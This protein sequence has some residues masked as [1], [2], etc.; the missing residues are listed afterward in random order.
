MKNKK[1]KKKNKFF[2][3]GKKFQKEFLVALLITIIFLIV[4]TNFISAKVINYDE[5]K[6]YIIDWLKNSFKFT[7]NQ[8]EEESLN[9]IEL[10]ELQLP[11]DSN[12]QKVEFAEDIKTEGVCID[13]LISSLT[14]NGLNSN[15]FWEDDKTAIFIVRDF[16]SIIENK[17]FVFN[18]AGKES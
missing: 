15:I 9:E 18:F 5:N 6:I 14:K 8:I 13:C 2:T 3:R 11:E 12:I 1:N 7:G 10:S 4:N 16:N 17:E